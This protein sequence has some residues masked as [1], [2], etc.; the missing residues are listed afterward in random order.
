M[1]QFVCKYHFQGTVSGINSNQPKPFTMI[2]TR[3]TLQNIWSSFLTYLKQKYK[4]IKCI[5]YITLHQVLY[6]CMKVQTLYKN[7]Q[8]F[9]PYRHAMYIGLYF[10]TSFLP[11]GMH[12]NAE[13]REF[14]INK[15]LQDLEIEL[16]QIA[17][18]Y[19]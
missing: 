1:L 15:R 13:T 11:S 9:Q 17:Q 10:F 3:D 19:T 5:D 7:L 16:K 18:L 4:T 6:D 8:F 2:K 14:L 12:F